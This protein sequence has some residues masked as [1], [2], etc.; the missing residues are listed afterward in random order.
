MSTRASLTCAS[1]VGS[2]TGANFLLETPGRSKILID[3]GLIQGE[4]V[5]MQENRKPF[6][7]DASL[8]NVLIVTHAHLDARPA[9]RCAAVARCRSPVLSCWHL[10]T[11][12][13]YSLLHSISIRGE[14]GSG[15]R[16][17]GLQYYEN[18]PG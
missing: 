12:P 4:K 14:V 5:A 10:F 8:I 6:G 18:N 3:C 1:G 2:V 7:Y 15:G 13:R 11:S 16:P 9:P 17:N